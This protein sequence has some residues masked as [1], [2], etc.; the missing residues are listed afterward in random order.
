MTDPIQQLEHLVT[1][2]HGTV[3]DDFI[4]ARDQMDFRALL[5]HIREV[6][7]K[8]NYLNTG[9]HTCHAECP[10]LHCVQRREIESLRRRAEAAEARVKALDALC[11]CYRT[12]RQPSEKL[13]D[14]LTRTAAA[15]AAQAKGE[16]ND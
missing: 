12:G 7:A 1:V 8:A 11:V 6:E 13:L 5:A 2:Q 3:P 10:R 15:L 4:E 9:V 14:E 16:S